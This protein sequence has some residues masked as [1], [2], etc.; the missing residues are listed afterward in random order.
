[1][2]RRRRKRRDPPAT[3]PEGSSRAG[4]PRAG[5]ERRTPR[6]V[7]ATVTLL[8]PLM[9]LALAEAGLRA[10]GYGRDLEPLFIDAPTLPG[11]RQANPRAVLRL[12]ADPRDAPAV[13]IETA[14]FRAAKPAGGLRV[15]VQGESSA[16]GFPYGLGASLA[17]VLEQRLRRAWPEREIEVISTAMAAVNSYAL[18]DFADEIVAQQPDAV[19]V[20]VGHNEYLGILGVGS[21]LRLAGSRW[22]TRAVLAAREWRLFQLAQALAGSAGRSRALPADAGDSLMARVAGERSIPLDSA[23]YRRG[24]AQFEGNLDALLTRY[25]RAG[26][27]VFIGTLASNERDQPPFAG[28]AAR[29]A[30]ERGRELLDTAPAGEARRWFLDA[31]DLDELRFR[32]PEAFNELVRQVAARHD[33]N[34]VESQQRLAGASEHGIIGADLMLEHVHPNLDGYFLLADAFYRALVDSGL[35]G[36]PQVSL[37]EDQARREMPVSELDRWFGEYKI[38]RIRA[39]WP[40][41]AVR[42]EPVLPAP[43]S[44]AERLAQLLYAERIDWPTA[45]DQLRRHY[46]ETGDL[47][48]FAHVTQILADAFPASAAIQFEC[49]AALIA[50]QR[51][52]D[53]VRYAKRAAALTPASVD[54][55][56][57]LGHAQALTGRRPEAI[58]ALERALSLE[59]GNETA[60][61]ALR[62]LGAAEPARDPGPAG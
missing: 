31:K 44:E 57:V 50:E 14:Y 61:N 56:L 22:I 33:A 2:S 36:A 11:W 34:V 1:M 45:Q 39:A 13:S 60:V 42:T 41:Q 6:W 21:T 15:I 9:V 12:F 43:G 18:L 20:Y 51:A 5:R 23:M 25:Q 8:L 10:G 4:A 26:V 52:P 38:A 16:A 27:P 48:G 55:W 54:A 59:P 32:A 40:F 49:A 46:R 29:Q 53:A 3:V 30:F 7:L 47:A 19:V 37:P 24:L 58:G 17:G 62:Q 28:D 35:A